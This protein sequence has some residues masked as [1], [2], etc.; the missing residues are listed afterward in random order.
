[1][2]VLRLVHQPVQLGDHPVG[3]DRRRVVLEL[4]APIRP[5][6]PRAARR[7]GPERPG[8]RSARRTCRGRPSPAIS[9]VRVSWASPIRPYC[10]GTS[11]LRSVGS[12][13]AWMIVLP[14]GMPTP[15]PVRAKLQP[16]PRMTSAS[17][18]K[19]LD[20]PRIGPPAAAQRQRVIFREG[21]LALDGGGHRDVPGFGQRLQLVP[22]LGVVHALAGVDHRPLRRPPAPWPPR[23][24][25]AGSGP[26]R[27]LKLGA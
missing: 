1:M 18:R 3:V 11:L 25:T 19:R 6:R 15:K 24:P 23:P 22:G 21:A 26:L 14:V 13:V 7:S 17:A 5:A 2:M 10:A 16:M 20:R 4:A 27:A 9:A 8:A 12:S